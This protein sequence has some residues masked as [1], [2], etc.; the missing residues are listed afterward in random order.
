MLPTRLMPTNSGMMFSRADV[1]PSNYRGYEADTRD[2]R[3]ALQETRS[4]GSTIILRARYITSQPIA[5]E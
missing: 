3:L 4:S 2:R 1:A 5:V